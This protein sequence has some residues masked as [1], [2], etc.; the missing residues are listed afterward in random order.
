[1][2]FRDYLKTQYHYSEKTLQAKEIHLLEWQQVCS[3]YQD[4]NQLR[5]Q[6]LF[7]IIALKRQKHYQTTINYHLK[8][9]EQYYYYLIKIGEIKIHPLKYFRI[10]TPKSPILKDFLS[11]EELN[12]I[13]EKM[14]SKGHYCGQFDHFAR[15]KKV[16]VGLLVYQG[17]STKD[18]GE[19]NLKDIDLENGT[20]EI[21]K[22]ENNAR[23]LEL[24][25]NQILDLYNYIKE[26]RLE[27]QKLLKQENN[28]KLFPFSAKSEVKSLT[29]GLKTSIRKHFELKDLYQ[30]RYS[31]IA[32]WLKTYNPRE[33]QYR[34][35]YKSLLSLEKYRQNELESLKQAIEKYHV[36]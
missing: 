34:A 7:K 9:L 10:K 26:T 36:F 32:L 4:L 17:L 31:R 15:R 23:K 6:E 20:I 1:M 11:A 30:I 14:P 12:L 19:I 29:K 21:P 35:G 22:G 25:S 5:Q 18:L 8:T 27:I 13:Y 24:S 3:Q 16:I 28:Q 33:T 2:T